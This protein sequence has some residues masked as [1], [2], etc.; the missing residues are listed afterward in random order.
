MSYRS[1]FRLPAM[2]FLAGSLVVLSVAD[3]GGTKD[4]H[5][6]AD[7]FQPS[8]KERMPAASTLAFVENRGQSILGSPTT[9]R[10]RTPPCSSPP[11]E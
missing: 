5:P 6:E 10:A 4:A 2:A 1:V 8:V 11:P 3:T 9:S 7:S